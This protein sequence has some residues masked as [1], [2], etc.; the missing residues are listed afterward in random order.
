MCLIECEILGVKS[1]IE[2]R[3]YF[4]CKEERKGVFGISLR[5]KK[6]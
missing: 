3:F 2:G 5:I 6:A 4:A 1:M